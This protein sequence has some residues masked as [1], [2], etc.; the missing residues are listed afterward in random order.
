MH[1]RHA[2]ALFAPL[3]IFIGCGGEVSGNTES[4]NGALPGNT[5]RT[6]CPSVAPES[7]S[8]CLQDGLRCEYPVQG[9]T[10]TYVC[11][12][13]ADRGWSCEMPAACMSR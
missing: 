5:A 11:K 1:I 4:G 2:L 8:A 7:A 3:A 12:C 9:C 6:E 13:S 10:L